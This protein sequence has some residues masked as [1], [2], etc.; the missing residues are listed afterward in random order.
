[1]QRRFS[2][3]HYLNN[4]RG[5]T[6]HYL[7][8]NLSQGTVLNAHNLNKAVMACPLVSLTLPGGLSTMPVQMEE[9]EGLGCH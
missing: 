2:T 9:H 8:R 4:E 1:M 7:S 6:T 5:T 3:D